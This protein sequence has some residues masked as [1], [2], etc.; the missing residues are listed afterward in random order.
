MS[1][2]LKKIPL[3]LMYLSISI[4]SCFCVITNFYVIP[5]SNIV[6]F[7]CL[8]DFYF[9][10]RKDMML[11]H[12]LVLCMLHYMNNHNDIENRSEIVSVILSTEISTIFLTTNNLLEFVDNMVIAKNINKLLFISSFVY[13]RIYN[14]T[15]Y[16]VLDNNIHKIFYYYSKNN[17][18]FCEIYG[19]VY[20]LFILNLYWCGIILKKTIFNIAYNK[21]GFIG[22]NGVKA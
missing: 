5:C 21:I 20:G 7:M 3:Q 19:G 18:E 1:E 13:Y 12:F 9:V 14:Y 17:I 16:L 8:I 11:H 2:I 6:G 4:V 15:Y 10:K 22:A